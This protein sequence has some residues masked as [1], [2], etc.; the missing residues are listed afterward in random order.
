MHSGKATIGQ[1]VAEC[2]SRLPTL[3]HVAGYNTFVVRSY[4]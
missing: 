2:A 1:V 4:K 3:T